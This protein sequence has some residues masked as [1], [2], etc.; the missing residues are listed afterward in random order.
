[1]SHFS[2]LGVRE[3]QTTHPQHRAFPAHHAR[4]LPQTTRNAHNASALR[5]SARCS[6]SSGPESVVTTTAPDAR[7]LDALH[8]P[9]HDVPAAFD[10]LASAFSTHCGVAAGPTPL[11]RGLVARDPAMKGAR[12]L[13]IDRA[14][15]LCLADKPG[16]TGDE[17]ARKVL[18]EW[19]LLHGRLPPLLLN[20]ILAGDTGWFPR[21]AAWLLWLASHGSG[22]WQLY[23]Q[24]LPTV[25]FV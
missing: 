7:P 4:P 23:T 25:F 17:F 2:Q 9:E 15:L 6:N 3:L 10:A 22:P 11:G 18:Q 21:M 14:G 20:Y 5:T 8:L 12:L 19:Q 24:M 16:D 13:S 1:M